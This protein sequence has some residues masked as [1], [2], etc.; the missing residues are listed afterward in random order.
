MNI[1][2]D[3]LHGQTPPGLQR[4]QA[5]RGG[6]GSGVCLRRAGYLSQ[7]PAQQHRS[8]REVPVLAALPLPCTEAPAGGAGGAPCRQEPSAPRAEPLGAGAAQPRAR[9]TTPALGLP[10]GGA[11]ASRALQ[12][13]RTPR[14]AGHP[15]RLQQPLQGCV[16]GFAPAPRGRNAAVLVPGCVARRGWWLSFQGFAVCNPLCLFVRCVLLTPLCRVA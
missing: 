2:S 8:I 16:W 14:A 13:H 7:N 1:S 6:G 5:G 15:L 12:Q 9:C 11:G 4:S 10:A 3:A